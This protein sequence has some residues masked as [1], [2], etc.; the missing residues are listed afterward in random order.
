MLLHHQFLHL[1]LSIFDVSQ[2]VMIV[3]DIIAVRLCPVTIHSYVS[4]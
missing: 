2:D 4:C 1:L 3:V